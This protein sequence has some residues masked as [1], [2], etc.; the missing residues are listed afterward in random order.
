MELKRMPPFTVAYISPIV[1]RKEV[2]NI[3]ENEGDLCLASDEFVDEHPIIYW[4]LVW[5]FSRNNLPS[6]LSGLYLSNLRK[7]LLFT[8]DCTLDYRNVTI[9]CVWDNEKIHEDKIRPMFY[10]WRQKADQSRESKLIHAL[11]TDS[12]PDSQFYLQELIGYIKEQKM[13][14][15]VREL[16]SKRFSSKSSQMK[17]SIYRDLLFLTF[18]A[19]GR[20]NIDSCK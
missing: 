4:N 18:I 6:H 10:L 19:I 20:E 17:Y 12:T 16:L 15:A 8:D 9:K 13:H 5:Y 7:Q 1:L 11:L 14:L 2:E 3:L